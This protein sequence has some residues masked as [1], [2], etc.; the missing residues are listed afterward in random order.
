[1]LI[2]KHIGDKIYLSKILSPYMIIFVV[3]QD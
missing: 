2:K 3:N 1:M